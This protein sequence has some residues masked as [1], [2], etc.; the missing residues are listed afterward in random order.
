MKHNLQYFFV[1]RYRQ[2]VKCKN[3]SLA[4][5]LWPEQNN[6]KLITF[7]LIEIITHAPI[8]QN[9]LHFYINLSK[10]Y[11]HP[12]PGIPVSFVH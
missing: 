7:M 10:M 12:S 3:I 1:F 2:I 11:A 8:Y 6:R 9:T 4:L 5:E